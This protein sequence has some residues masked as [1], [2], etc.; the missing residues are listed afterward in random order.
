[1]LPRASALSLEQQQQHTKEWPEGRRWKA[2]AI[3]YPKE[4][5]SAGALGESIQMQL[6]RC[7]AQQ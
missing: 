6:S 5:G 7:I 1:M 2:G 4:K 3:D